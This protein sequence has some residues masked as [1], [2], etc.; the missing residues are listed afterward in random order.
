MQDIKWKFQITDKDNRI[1]TYDIIHYDICIALCDILAEKTDILAV[2]FNAICACEKYYQMVELVRLRT[3][4]KIK[5]L[6][7]VFQMH[8][9]KC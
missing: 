2:D 8:N 9:V 5:L 6:N 4:M 7:A 1:V 3:G